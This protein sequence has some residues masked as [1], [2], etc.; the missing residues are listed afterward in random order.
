MRLIIEGRNLVLKTKTRSHIERRVAFAFAR[1]RNNIERTRITLSE[2]QASDGSMDNQ[3]RVE[4]LMKDQVE[5]VI[6]DVQQDI[7]HAIDRALFRASYNV[8]Q[9]IKRKFALRN[10]SHYEK[11]VA[12][13]RNKTP[14]NIVNI[15]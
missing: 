1:H 7:N 13:S 4:I 8:Q 10:K 9:R 15:K 5:M 11:I 3:C 12:R 6:S 2:V 14:I